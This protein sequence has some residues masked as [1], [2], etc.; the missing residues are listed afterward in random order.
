MMV[1]LLELFRLRQMAVKLPRRENE[2]RMQA[3]DA[4]DRFDACERPPRHRPE[5]TAVDE[6]QHHTLPPRL[7]PAGHVEIRR[8]VAVDLYLHA[9]EH[10]IDGQPAAAFMQHDVAMPEAGLKET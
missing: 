3:E 6:A 10:G 2:G 8:Q 1:S 9:V 7:Q 5:A 4:L